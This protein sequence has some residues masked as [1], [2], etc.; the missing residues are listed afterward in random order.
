MIIPVTSNNY[1]FPP[2]EETPYKE[3]ERK[4]RRNTIINPMTYCWLYQGHTTNSGHCQIMVDR[5]QQYIHRISAAIYLGYDLLDLGHQINHRDD[6][7]SSP[8]CWNPEHLYIGTKAENSQDK[9]NSGYGVNQNVSKTH[10]PGGH[11]YN[12]V[13]TYITKIGKRMCRVCHKERERVRQE[14][15]RELY[16]N[17]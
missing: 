11:E 12:E 5:S 13:N 8:N 16:G 1:G 10:C 9:V 6:I 4:M 17:K 15:I 7:C 14:K 3:F 2:L